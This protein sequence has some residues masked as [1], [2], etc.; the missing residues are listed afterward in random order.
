MKIIIFYI[1]IQKLLKNKKIKL[2]DNFG[3]LEIYY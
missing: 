2:Y 1:K 3:D